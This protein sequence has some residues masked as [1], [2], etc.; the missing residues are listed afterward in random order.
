MFAPFLDGNPDYDIQNLA[1][2]TGEKSSKKR[3]L[4]KGYEHTKRC[5]KN[6]P[7][8]H[9]YTSYLKDLKWIHPLH[10]IKPLIMPLLRHKF[11]QIY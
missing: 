8:E 6:T 1:V 9:V 3:V 11:L 7:R 5:Y 10:T 2:W 4:K